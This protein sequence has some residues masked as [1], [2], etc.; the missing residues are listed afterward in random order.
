MANAAYGLQFSRTLHGGQPLCKRFYVPSTDSTPLFRGD[1]VTLTTTTGVLD[2]KNEV[3]TITR[4]A[5]GQILL[6][7]I[8][9]FYPDSSAILTGSSRAASTARYV[10]VNIDPDSCYYAQ[11]DD[12]GGTM[13]AALIASFSNANIIVATGSVYT[14][15]SGTLIDS[16]TATA[17]AADVKV[18]GIRE[19]SVNAGGVATCELEVMILAPA[20]K[21]TDSQS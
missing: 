6:G 12:V 15:L 18:I 5:T 13:T 11:Q 16:S 21:S 9:D 19:D 7:V 14:G 2:P 4:A 1:V 17:S 3:P 10:S 8:E 20:I